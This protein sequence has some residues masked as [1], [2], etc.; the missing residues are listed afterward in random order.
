MDISS[1]ELPGSEVEDIW[2]DGDRVVVRFSRAYI[3]KSMTGSK[4]RTRW[5]QAGELIFTD[6]TVEAPCPKGRHICAG[7]DV[8]ENVY[9][10]RDMIPTPLDSRGRARCDLRFEGTEERLIVRAGSVRL[11]MEDRPHYIEHIKP[12][13]P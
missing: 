10:Y 8:G 2:I 12:Q 3:V 9:T 4:D 5:W 11:D 6:A 7:G 1:I 13:V